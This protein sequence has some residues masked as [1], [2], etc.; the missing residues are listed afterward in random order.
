MFNKLIITGSILIFSNN[1]F[2]ELFKTDY[3]DTEFSQ[4]LSDDNFNAEL[5][6]RL[7][8]FTAKDKLN[9]QKWN[10]DKRD[11][12][13]YKKLMLTTNAAD[14]YPNAWPTDVLYMY[15][16]TP[17]EKSK[18]LK[19]TVGFERQ[20]QKQSYQ[21]QAAV[22]QYEN[23]Q[24]GLNLYD[25]TTE[26]VKRSQP[27]ALRD[28]PKYKEVRTQ[29]FIDAANCDAQCNEFAQQLIK[30]KSDAAVLDLWFVNSFGSDRSIRRLAQQWDIKPEDI[31]NYQVTINHD[32]GNARSLKDKH[33][34]Q[35]SY[36]FAVRTTSFGESI[37]KP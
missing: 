22:D 30:T 25:T 31:K 14:L 16:E 7:T 23:N 17:G 26:R 28:L 20:K 35:G 8:T 27:P 36:P 2:A 33:S 19:L 1:V 11:W 3:V 32:N 10:I 6:R 12:L 15:A 4:S 21:Y 37:V 9:A 29:L 24:L 18:Y 13:Q 5:N 34:Y